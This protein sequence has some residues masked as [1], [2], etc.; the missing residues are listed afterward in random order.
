VINITTRTTIVLNVQLDDNVSIWL[1]EEEGFKLASETWKCRRRNNVVVTACSNTDVQDWKLVWECLDGTAP[2]YLCELCVPVASASGRQHL[3][4]AS[5]GLRAY[6]CKFL[7]PE[8]WSVG[9]ALLSRDRHVEKS[10]CRLTETGDDQRRFIGG[11]GGRG[12]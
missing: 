12:P 8:P 5:T 2:G 3:G 1:L 7:E 11:T 10:S 9:G 6:N 4:S